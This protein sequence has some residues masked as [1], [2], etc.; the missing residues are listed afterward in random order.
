[1]EVNFHIQLLVG[2]CTLASAKGF[3][4]GVKNILKSHYPLVFHKNLL[5][6]YHEG[7]SAGYPF[8]SERENT[9]IP[10]V[11]RACGPEHLRASQTC[12]CSISC[13]QKRK[14][15]EKKKIFFQ[16]F[17]FKIVGPEVDERR[18]RFYQEKKRK[19]GK[20]EWRI[21]ASSFVCALVLC[22]QISL[23]TLASSFNDIW[24]LDSL[25]IQSL[26]FCQF[27]VRVDFCISIFFQ[28]L[29][30]RYSEKITKI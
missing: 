10:S 24:F 16:F 27:I 7:G 1:M 2:R 26:G 4:N 6:I 5:S 29:K 9:L 12:Y 15:F 25:Y 13:C 8:L 3:Q 20:C 22:G 11:Q 30:F 28:Y 23:G 19:K 21:K 17:F 14:I 18:Y